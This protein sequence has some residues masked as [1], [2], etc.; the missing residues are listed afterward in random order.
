M[1]TTNAIPGPHSSPWNRGS[2]KDFR[3]QPYFRR[4]GRRHYF[5]ATEIELESEDEGFELPAW[6]V[7]EVSSDTRYFNSN[8]LKNPYR[9]WKNS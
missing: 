1:S 7:K 2:T 3:R 8:L 5:T 6:A 9:A 4:V